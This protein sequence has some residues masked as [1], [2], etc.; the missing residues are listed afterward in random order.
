MRE[1]A[2][3]D[4]ADSGQLTGKVMRLKLMV[5]VLVSG[6]RR[7]TAETAICLVRQAEGCTLE[8]WNLHKGLL[9]DKF[10]R[11][12]EEVRGRRASAANA[13]VLGNSRKFGFFG[14]QVTKPR[15]QLELTLLLY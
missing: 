6:C 2:L 7:R 4:L 12:V 13:F 15:S 10:S 8:L 1:P 11:L 3:I 9:R 14:K 5:M